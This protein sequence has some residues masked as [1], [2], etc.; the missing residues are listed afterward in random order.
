MKKKFEI[1]TLFAFI[2]LGIFTTTSCRKEKIETAIDNLVTG[3]DVATTQ[4]LMEDDEDEILNEQVAGARGGCAT[5]KFLKT[6]GI[7]PQTII[8]DYPATGCMDKKG[9]TRTGTLTVEV[10]ADPKLKGSTIVVTP[11]NFTIDGIKV[12]GVRTWTNNGKDAAGNKNLNRVVKDGK[13]TFPNG[14]VATFDTNET[15]KQI[16]GAATPDDKTDDVVEITGTRNGINRNGK[17][18]SAEI[19]TKLVKNFSCAHIVSGIVTITN[20]TS[21]RSIDFGDGTCDDKATVTLA[22]G[23]TKEVTL[24]KWW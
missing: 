15:L 10:S 3:Q 19:T 23:T 16:A 7:F 9:R 5:V 13:L 22:N 14:K 11:T 18:Y 2:A 21:S 1:L 4:G 20:D 8:V 6:K 17:A 12:E 24:K